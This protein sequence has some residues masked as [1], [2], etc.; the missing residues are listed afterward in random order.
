MSFWEVS[1]EEIFGFVL[2]RP[3]GVGKTPPYKVCVKNVGTAH[4]ISPSTYITTYTLITDLK[5]ETTS[6]QR[7]WP[8]LAKAMGW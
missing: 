1:H 6:H 4:V 8:L 5:S 7:C 2:V 3:L